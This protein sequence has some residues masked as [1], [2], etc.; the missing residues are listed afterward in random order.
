MLVFFYHALNVYI[1]H[2]PV[3]SACEWE[4]ATCQAYDVIIS[5]A[6]RESTVTNRDRHYS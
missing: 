1:L 4:D 2:R 5:K 6:I 3:C